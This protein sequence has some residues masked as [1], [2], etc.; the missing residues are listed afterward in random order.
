MKISMR[1][2]IV[3]LHVMLLLCNYVIFSAH[4]CVLLHSRGLFNDVAGKNA[5]ALKSACCSTEI[6]FNSSYTKVVIHVS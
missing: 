4:S 3:L 2:Y 1:L 5:A 6:Q